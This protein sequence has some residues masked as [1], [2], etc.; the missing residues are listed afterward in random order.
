LAE[1][2]IAGVSASEVLD[3]R[4]YPT[5]AVTVTTSVGTRANA[6]VPSGASTGAREALELR[7]EDPDRYYGKGVLKA[8]E[9]VNG[10]I[11][12]A[13]VGQRLGGLEEQSAL[14]RMM[15]ELDGTDTKSR[16]GAN[17]ILGVSIAAAR[18]AAHATYVPL[19]HFLGGDTARRLPAPMMNVLNGGVHADNTVDFQEF[20][21]YPVGAPSFAE[22]L[23]WGS[24]IFHALRGV[25]NEQGYGTAVGD[26]G[27]FAPD[28]STNRAA[29][30]LIMIAIE[31]AGY[32]LWEQ[33]AIA[34]DPAAS[35][36]YRDGN[37]VLAGEDAT[38]STEEMI[39]F[40]EEWISSYPIVSIEDGLDEDDWEGWSALTGVLGERVQ[41]VG[42]DL[43]V[44]N[45]AILERGI[46]ERSAN[47][48]LIKLNQIGTVT[49]TLEAIRM[50]QEAGFGVVVSHRSGETE[51]TT[52]A[53]L[54]VGS[55]CGQIKTGSLCRSERVCKYNRLLQIER[56][57]GEHAEFAGRSALAGM[58]S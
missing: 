37:Y 31:K 32:Q 48:I 18:A 4:G 44:T 19:Y 56:E 7:D 55:G 42:D 5:V 38:K 13:V 53:D 39:A 27:G 21:I 34:L 1:P 25:L 28:L 46:R 17:A 8:V 22:A 11:A 49:E 50:A 29:I 45:S 9:H 23:R 43:F 16:L 2:T 15:I 36:F 52:I 6:T 57:L 54:A 24:E 33:V 47:A 12:Q 51:D 58:G 26:E 41:L 20:M 10:E 14:D 35:E 40:W 30:E 3:S